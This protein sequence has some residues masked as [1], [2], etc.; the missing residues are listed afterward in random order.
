MAVSHRF[1]FRRATAGIAIIAC[2]LLLSAAAHAAQ[3]VEIGTRPGL[4]VRAM[5]LEPKQPIGSVILL[6]G[7]HGNLDLSLDGAIGWGTDNQLVRTR[8]H[9]VRQGFVTLV[10]DIAPD[11]KSGTSA[12]DGYRMSAAH[13]E[14]IGELVAY[15]RT[16][17]APVY[18]VGTSRASLSVANAAARLV[19]RRAPDAL[20]I[21]A[22][23]LM[24]MDEAHPSVQ[25]SISGLERIAQPTLLLGHAHDRCAYTADMARTFVRLLKGAS[26]VDVVVLSGG[27]EGTGDPCGPRSHHGFLGIDEEVVRTIA[28]WLRA[29]PRR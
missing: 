28:D 19:G 11:L 23:M 5:L 15:V 27:E 13:A 3:V 12:A 16:I 4:F 21:T 1:R 17:A 26:R 7:G 6:A 25:T 14:D 20:V 22:G 24:H 2:G 18:L 8:E 10:P 29:R 9:Y